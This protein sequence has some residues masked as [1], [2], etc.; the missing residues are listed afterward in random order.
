MGLS[1]SEQIALLNEVPRRQSFSLVLSWI[2]GGSF[3]VKAILQRSVTYNKASFVC[4]F[5]FT[6]GL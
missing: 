4:F 5:Y 3:K 2:A 6:I 1:P